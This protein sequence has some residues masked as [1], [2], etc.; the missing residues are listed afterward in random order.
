MFHSGLVI[1]CVGLGPHPE[2]VGPEGGGREDAV[3]SRL[4]ALEGLA[5][6][7]RGDAENL[8]CALLQDKRFFLHLIQM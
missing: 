7:L 2:V 5:E 8:F 4:V 3:V 6:L 1:V